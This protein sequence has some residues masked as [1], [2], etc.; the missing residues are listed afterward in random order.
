MHMSG[1][2]G[3]SLMTLKLDGQ[4]V[5]DSLDLRCLNSLASKFEIE[6]ETVN[7]FH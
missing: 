7:G 6:K 1:F 4:H 5:V 3:S 2:G